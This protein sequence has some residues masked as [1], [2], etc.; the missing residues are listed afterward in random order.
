MIGWIGTHVFFED[1]TFN[2]FVS[3]WLFNLLL[4]LTCFQIPVLLTSSDIFI[5]VKG[6]FIIL[7]LMRG[8]CRFSWNIGG[9]VLLVSYNGIA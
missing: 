7:P 2:S 1:F 5:D 4:L 6:I 9:L 3:I 8:I